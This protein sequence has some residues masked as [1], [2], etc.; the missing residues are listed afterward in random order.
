MVAINIMSE[1]SSDKSDKDQSTKSDD[2]RLPVDY[3]PLD[4]TYSVCID[5]FSR[6]RNLKN[7]EQ[8]KDG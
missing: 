5:S 8:G 7:K 4:G 2:D 3:K 1:S 6:D